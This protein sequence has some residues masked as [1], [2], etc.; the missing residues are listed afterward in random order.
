MMATIIGAKWEREETRGTIHGEALQHKPHWISS[1]AG[2]HQKVK[3]EDRYK[4][5]IGFLAA[6]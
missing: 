5:C 3:E 6:G 1:F 2:G 4:E